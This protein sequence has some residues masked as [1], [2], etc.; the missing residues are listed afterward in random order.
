MSLIAPILISREAVVVLGR[1]GDDFYLVILV[2]FSFLFILLI[3]HCSFT[4]FIFLFRNNEEN[5]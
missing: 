3:I 5:K 2:L 4:V 1:G